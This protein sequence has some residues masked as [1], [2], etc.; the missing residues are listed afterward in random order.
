M[1]L[2]FS[3]NRGKVR[4]STSIASS[5]PSSNN[6]EYVP[7]SDEEQGEASEEES[8]GYTESTGPRRVTRQAKLPFSPKK[9]RSQRIIALDDSESE[10]GSAR[11]QRRLTRARAVKLK[12][13]SDNSDFEDDDDDD[14]S[15]YAVRRRPEKSK[16]ASRPKFTPPSYGNIRPIAALDYDDYPSD[17]ENEAL[18]EHR[19]ICEKCH[20]VPAHQLLQTMKKKSK[21]KKRK[22]GSED[23]FDYSDDEDRYTALGGWVRW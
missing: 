22:R 13:A 9:S 1:K 7:D 18:R 3:Q 23:E 20:L 15:D 2:S 10:R 16:K 19:A 5:L 21:G 11:P 4:V 6:I 8:D 17:P 14:A 12:L